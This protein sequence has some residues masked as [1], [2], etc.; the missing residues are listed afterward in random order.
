LQEGTYSARVEVL[1]ENRY[2][3]PVQFQI[4]FKK[5]LK[6]VAESIFVAP[7]AAKPEISVSAAPIMVAK[8][9]QQARPVVIESAP[10]PVVQAASRVVE[11]KEVV[12]V[13]APPPKKPA[14]A[15]VKTE[16]QQKPVPKLSKLAE[17]SQLT[18]ELIAELTR[19][20]SSPKRKG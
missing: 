12:P 11:K 17:S 9:T 10:Q 4:N 5:A 8:P 7:R 16:I 3:S 2:F 13:Q 20:F 1:I 14:P 6:V 15:Q 19:S 18:D